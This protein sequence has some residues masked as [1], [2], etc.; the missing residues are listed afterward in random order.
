MPTEFRLFESGPG[1][2]FETYLGVNTGSLYRVDLGQVHYGGKSLL[3]LLT[4]AFQ[5]EGGAENLLSVP[6]QLQC[7]ICGK[8]ISA[9][10]VAVDGEEIVTAFLA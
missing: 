9:A 2:D 3:E 4:S 1:G 8:A 5:R 6:S 10:N 7:K